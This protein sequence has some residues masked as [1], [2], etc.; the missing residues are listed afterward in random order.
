MGAGGVCIQ[1][2][3]F[4]LFLLDGFKILIFLFYTQQCILFLLGTRGLV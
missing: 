2:K 1:W 4:P 3:L